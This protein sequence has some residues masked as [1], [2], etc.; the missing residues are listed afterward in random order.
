[1]AAVVRRGTWADTDALYAPMPR[2]LFGTHRT[3]F[4]AK[5]RLCTSVSDTRLHTATPAWGAG[6]NTC[7]TINSNPQCFPDEN[8][9]YVCTASEKARCGKKKCHRTSRRKT[10]VCLDKPVDVCA[11]LEEPCFHG[12]KC[13]LDSAAVNGFKCDGCPGRHSDNCRPME[14]DF[15]ICPQSDQGS[16]QPGDVCFKRAGDTVPFCDASPPPSFFDFFI[17]PQVD[18]GCGDGGCTASKTNGI[19]CMCNKGYAGPGCLAC[20]PG[21]TQPKC[22]K[23]CDLDPC[24]GGSC[25]NEAD[26]ASGRP[27]TCT[28]P[29][30][31]QGL[32]PANCG[33]PTPKFV[34]PAV[35]IEADHPSGSDVGTIFSQVDAVFN[36]R[37]TLGTDIIIAGAGGSGARQRRSLGSLFDLDRKTGQLITLQSIKEYGGKTITL[38]VLAQ[39]RWGELTKTVAK[40]WPINIAPS[41]EAQKGADEGDDMT[42]IIIIVIVLLL[43]LCCIAALIWY[44][45]CRDKDDEEEEE[46]DAAWEANKYKFPGA[47]DEN[48]IENPAYGETGD[49]PKENG[50]HGTLNNDTYGASGAP[51]KERERQPSISNATYDTAQPAMAAH[52]PG[53]NSSPYDTAARRGGEATP[54]G[55]SVYD[56]AHA[57][58][59]APGELD[60]TTGSAQ[61]QSAYDVA[62]KGQRQSA[63][64]VASQ[65]KKDKKNK[66]KTKKNKAADRTQSAYD[67]A[68]Q[69][70]R[71]SAYD[72][73]AREREGSIDNGIYDAA[74]GGG[75]NQQQSAYDVASGNNPQ[76][77]SAYDVASGNNPQKQSAY[78]VASGN[79]PRQQ[80]S[81]DVASQQG[82]G[83]AAVYD[84]GGGYGSLPVSATYD[85][86]T[87]YGE[88]G[89]ALYDTAALNP[90]NQGQALYDTAAVN[91]T[92]AAATNYEAASGGGPNVYDTAAQGARGKNKDYHDAEK[93]DAY[94]GGGDGYL[95]VV[96]DTQPQQ[97]NYDVASSSMPQQS[98]YDI[99][100]G[101]LR[102]P[103]VYDMADNTGQPTYGTQ[104]RRP[105]CLFLSIACSRSVFGS[106]HCF[107][108][109][110][111]AHA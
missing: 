37:Y 15:S 69:G 4:A 103:S 93:F 97:S 106:S 39:T 104:H 108:T 76:K 9:F 59:A 79:N 2:A 11:E 21:T 30:S 96:S 82:G 83:G 75:G 10:A 101:N 89:Q 12:G 55:N 27:Y 65:G 66:K 49:Q 42:L 51:P 70:Q 50:S 35:Q 98:A 61:R 90:G 3:C 80:S 24:F 1:M 34:I 16:C 13:T 22:T 44:F 64:D 72:V 14:F 28:C 68:S 57:Q 52:V 99:A 67:V 81:Y 29:A 43:L 48:I 110:V 20:G 17:C 5:A 100:S 45:C 105:C 41:P 36:Q 74:G 33:P 85:T 107:L 102:Q 25:K 111:P 86:A 109:C 47:R 91:G 7:R 63:Y 95:D 32:D 53:R 31:P 19:S 87:D 6:K 78:D 62:S 58:K 38:T 94:E 88:V 73:A 56:M 23:P 40:P 46:K 60:K 84:M 54:R 77:Q 18:D 26:A 8:N 92:F 71:Q